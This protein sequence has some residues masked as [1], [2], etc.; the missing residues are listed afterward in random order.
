MTE[1]SPAGSHRVRIVVLTFRAILAGSVCNTRA[2]RTVVG[3]PV[4]HVY[5]YTDET[6][7]F[8]E[9]ECPEKGRNLEMVQASFAAWSRRENRPDA[10]LHRTFA[11]EREGLLGLAGRFEPGHPRWRLPYR[12][13]ADG[14]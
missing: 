8:D 12:K 11:E 7:V 5:G 3:A 6:G 13:P 4:I 14:Q 1:R 2:W 10:V 9:M